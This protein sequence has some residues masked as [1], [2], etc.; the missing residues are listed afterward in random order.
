MSSDIS[1]KRHA[2][3]S[4]DISRPRPALQH[5]PRE[6]IIPIALEEGGYVSTPTSST[7]SIADLGTE[8]TITAAAAKNEERPGYFAVS[9]VVEYP[10]GR[11]VV[12][13]SVKSSSSMASL[14]ETGH[15]RVAQQR[16]PGGGAF[17]LPPTP[18]SSG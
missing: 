15:A 3:V 10:G 17:S 13:T 4:L 7:S 2:Q 9:S 8:Q 6:F 16:V 1:S 11:R 14:G 5:S 12:S 18:L